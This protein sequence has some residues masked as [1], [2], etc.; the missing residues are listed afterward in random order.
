MQIQIR[1]SDGK[2]FIK[3]DCPGPHITIDDKHPDFKKIMQGYHVE[4]AG[5]IFKVTEIKDGFDL[6]KFIKQLQNKT[7]SLQDIR[8]YLL[9]ELL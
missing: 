7:A 1:Q 6:D 4:T 2:I 3:N 9:Q 8:E 5:G